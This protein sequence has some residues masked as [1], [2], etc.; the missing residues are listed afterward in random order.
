MV[1][2]LVVF[3]FGVLTIVGGMLVVSY[4]LGERHEDRATGYPFESGITRY[5]IF[6]EADE[7][8]GQVL[9]GGDVLRDLRSGGGLHHRLGGLGA[10]G[11]LVGIYRDRGLHQ[12]SS[13][14]TGVPLAH[15][16]TGVGSRVSAIFA[17]AAAGLT[18]P[19]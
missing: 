16:C 8:L 17:D 12:R 11:R 9:S 5:E 7:D 10:R 19:G 2:P 4:L 1:W 18:R 3:F 14:R 6:V 15:W 13:G